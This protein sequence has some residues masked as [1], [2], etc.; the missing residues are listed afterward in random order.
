M[1]HLRKIDN[2]ELASLTLSYKKGN[3]PKFPEIRR[4]RLHQR[5]FQ[6]FNEINL[7]ASRKSGKDY[8]NN[9]G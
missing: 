1:T 8:V 6:G 4:K 2:P 7:S 9:E 3:S 5:R